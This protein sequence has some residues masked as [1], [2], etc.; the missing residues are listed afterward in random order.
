MTGGMGQSKAD[1]ENFLNRKV[2]TIPCGSVPNGDDPHGRI[3]H[4]YSYAAVSQYSINEALRDNSVRYI[5]FKQRVRSI[6]EVSW[7]IVVD[8]KDGYRQ[9]PLNPKD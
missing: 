6:S 5:S 1:V 4:D 8:L 7:Y 3:V 9:L 2:Y